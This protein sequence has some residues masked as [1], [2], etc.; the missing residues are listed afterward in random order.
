MKN[1]RKF[2]KTSSLLVASAGVMGYRAVHSENIV[3]TSNEKENMLVHNVYFWLKS[4]LDN[5]DKKAFE[6]GI[7]DL[8]SNVKE[9]KKAEIGIPAETPNR[10]VVDKSFGY[11]LFIWFNN[12]EDHN[13]YQS[14]PAHKKFINDC[15]K[16]WTKVQVYDS[17]LI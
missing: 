17:K 15:S 12:V 2:L 10:D 14:H 7:K 8:V 3:V 4:E 16:Y 5:D 9:V 6:K 1:R 13:I 11:S